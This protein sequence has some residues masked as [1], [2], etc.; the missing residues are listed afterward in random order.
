MM[1]RRKRSL[2]NNVWSMMTASNHFFNQ[3]S[4]LPVPR[5][6]HG[7]QQATGIDRA[8]RNHITK[9]RSGMTSLRERA[10]PAVQNCTALN[11]KCT[12]NNR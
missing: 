11:S 3:V 2:D 10:E 6:N 7:L 12:I 8:N 1:K 4:V 9:V 5:S